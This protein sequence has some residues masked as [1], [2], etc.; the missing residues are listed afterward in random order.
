MAVGG[1]VCNAFRFVLAGLFSAFCLTWFQTALSAP[2]SYRRKFNAGCRRGA[3]SLKTGVT[4]TAP[5]EAPRGVFGGGRRSS[6]PVSLRTSYLCH[7]QPGRGT[8]GPQGK[9]GLRLSR[10]YRCWPESGISELGPGSQ[11][12]GKRRPSVGAWMLEPR[13]SLS[14][15]PSR[16]RA[17]QSER[18]GSPSFSLPHFR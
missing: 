17:R 8:G 12:C 5:A 6:K 14:F 1:V 10:R 4:D 13:V 9:C 15:K 2:T 11:G 3:V 7:H 16:R 18:M